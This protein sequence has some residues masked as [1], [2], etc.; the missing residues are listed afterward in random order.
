MMMM[1]SEYGSSIDLS[2]YR[3]KRFGAQVTCEGESLI[4]VI[5]ELSKSEDVSCKWDLQPCAGAVVER[6]SCIGL[7]VYQSLLC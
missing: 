1:N 4:V 5:V 3:S 6:A 2:G 7:P